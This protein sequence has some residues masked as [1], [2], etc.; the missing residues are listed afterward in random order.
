[1]VLPTTFV[2]NFDTITASELGCDVAEYQA[3]F[4]T[5]VNDQFGAHSATE[6]AVSCLLIARPRD[7]SQ[8]LDT[9]AIFCPR[10]FG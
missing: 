5:L 8:V 6:V 3:F 2:A 9:V 1:M 4:K 10:E 7:H